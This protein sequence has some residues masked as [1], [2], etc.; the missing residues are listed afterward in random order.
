MSNSNSSLPQEQTHIRLWGNRHVMPLVVRQ[1]I[2]AGIESRE[3]QLEASDTPGNKGAHER[4]ALHR[5][6]DE[7]RAYLKAAG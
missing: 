7:I 5:E 2:E 6:I 3:A 4:N 1:L